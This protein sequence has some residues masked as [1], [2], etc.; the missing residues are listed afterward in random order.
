[1]GQSELITTQRDVLRGHGSPLSIGILGK[2]VSV[3]A[4]KYGEAG[5]EIQL[6]SFI[7]LSTGWS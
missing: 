6:H 4:M 5:M 7:P 1:V 3:H 2:T